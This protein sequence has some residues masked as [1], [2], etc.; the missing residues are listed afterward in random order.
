MNNNETM[1]TTAD[2]LRQIMRE[3]GLKQ[4]DIIELSKP[5]AQRYGTKLTRPDI[6]QYCSGKVAP[7]QKKLFLLAATL[8]VNEA[9][10][11]GYNVTPERNETERTLTMSAEELRMVLKFRE[12]PEEIK[13]TIRNILNNAPKKDDAKSSNSQNRENIA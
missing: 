9:W 2:R 10:L 7:T 13:Q 5:F 6:S 3:R 12:V 8:N 11:M 1:E 4:A